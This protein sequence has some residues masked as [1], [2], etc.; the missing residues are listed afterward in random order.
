MKY[1]RLFKLNYLLLFAPLSVL[2]AYLHWEDTYTFIFAFL[3]IVPLAGMIGWATEELTLFTGP[4]IG[5]LLN[6]TFGNATELILAIAA[7]NAGLIGVVKATLTGSI[8]S[9]LL[10]VLGFS[11]FLGA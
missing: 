9:N 4:N 6:A 7:L 5:G 10:L 3:S 11:L 2:S 8:I 1:L